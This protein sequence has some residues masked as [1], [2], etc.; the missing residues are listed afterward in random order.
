MTIT[1]DGKKINPLHPVIAAMITAN[2]ISLPE[3]FTIIIYPYYSKQSISMSNSEE[4][5]G[6]IVEGISRLRE[7]QHIPS[8]EYRASNNLHNDV[9]AFLTNQNHQI[10]FR[11]NGATVRY[12]LIPVQLA[13][14]GITFPY[15][16]LVYSTKDGSDSYRS[17]NIYPCLSGN[18]DTAFGGTGNTCVGDLSNYNF[19]SLYVLGNMNIN[20]M[21]YSEVFTSESLTFIHACQK[22]STA[23][24]KVAAGEFP[25]AEEPANND[26]ASEEASEEES[27]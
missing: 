13:T 19:S 8:V 6:K 11:E 1:F 21:Y 9:N 7:E 22:V 18:I 12:A 23:F 16:G 17:M 14:H 4:Y 25:V 10:N 3:T 26:D 27:A 15:Y 24:L 20:S 5:E 2:E